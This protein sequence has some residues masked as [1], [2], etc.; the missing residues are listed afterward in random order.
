MF[1][2][3]PGKGKHQRKGGGGSSQ[4]RSQNV[5]DNDPAFSLTVKQ[6][7]K[8]IQVVHHA[9]LM[10]AQRGGSVVKSFSQKAS[11]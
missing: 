9:G 3:A 2:M 6:L 11:S 7:Y 4:Q 8:F 1:I 10:Y 5:G